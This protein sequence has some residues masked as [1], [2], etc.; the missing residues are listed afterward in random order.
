MVVAADVV[1]FVF[2]V[3]VVAA[4]PHHVGFFGRNG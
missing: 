3:P 2:A 1:A 4:H